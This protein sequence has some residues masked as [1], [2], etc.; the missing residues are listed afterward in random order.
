[1]AANDDAE[2]TQ[3]PCT[4]TRQAPGIGLGLSRQPL[5]RL[6]AV[7]ER[8]ETACWDPARHRIMARGADLAT[9]QE[10]SRP[11]RLVSNEAVIVKIIAATT[12]SEPRILDGRYASTRPCV[13]QSQRAYRRSAGPR[14]D[15]HPRR[16]AHSKDD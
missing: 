15:A 8:G 13:A 9:H 12:S 14:S 6:G 4:D 5:W 7:P 3:K 1:M 11:D 2:Y 10:G 16:Y